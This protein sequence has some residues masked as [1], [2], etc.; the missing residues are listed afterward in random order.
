MSWYYQ[1]IK[2]SVD[3]FSAIDSELSANNFVSAW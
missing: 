1:E 3:R 2:S